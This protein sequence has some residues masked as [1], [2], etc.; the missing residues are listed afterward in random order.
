MKILVLVGGTNDPSNAEYLADLFVEGIKNIPMMETEKV[1][2]RDVPLE[3]FTL[4]HY[5]GKDQGQ[6][7]RDLQTKIQA[8]NALVIATPVWNFGI[9]AH[10]KNLID[11][12]GVF[13][14]DAE[15]R[16]KGQL[17][18]IPCYF[19]FT[20]G[21]PRVAWKGLMRFTTMHVPEAFRYFDASPAGSHYEGKC[22]K[23]RGQ[24]A[25]VLDQRP[26]LKETMRRKGRKFALVTQQFT[27]TG[28]LPLTYRIIAK[29]YWLGQRI[30]AKF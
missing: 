6:L 16:S 7:F 11:H 22:M 2:V 24:F 4:A 15:T 18:G 1:R 13:A 20:G 17:K 29:L 3:H 21:A 25:F 10:L 26:E 30:L 5:E 19:L 27:T 9:P 28:Q 14:L 23:G 8:A 12:M